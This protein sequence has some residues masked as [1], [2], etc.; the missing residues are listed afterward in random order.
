MCKKEKIS[1]SIS[2]EI[3]I[4]D[5]M[6]C[7]GCG[8]GF[9]SKNDLEC[10]HIMPESAGGKTDC[11]NLQALCKHCNIAK[12]QSQRNALLEMSATNLDRIETRLERPKIGENQ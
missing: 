3:K 1:A 11:D 9:L 8:G 2:A 4:R 12:S 5:N 7:R 6:R 10:D